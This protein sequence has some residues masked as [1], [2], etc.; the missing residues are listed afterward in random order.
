MK[1]S[2]IFLIL[3]FLIAN[4]SFSEDVSDPNTNFR[5]GPKTGEKWDKCYRDFDLTDN[6]ICENTTPCFFLK[7]LL[8]IGTCESK[9]RICTVSEDGH[10]MTCQNQL[11][12]KYGCKTDENG[13][14]SCASNITI[15]ID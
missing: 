5:L 12:R 15:N 1:L 6:I 3:S 13:I 7:R 11:N 10:S 14:E 2:Y 4:P 8:N 9:K